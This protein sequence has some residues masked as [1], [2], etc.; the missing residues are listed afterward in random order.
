M[1]YR[2]IVGLVIGVLAAPARAETMPAPFEDMPQIICVDRDKAIELLGVYEQET[3]R[4]EELLADC[5]AQG[6]CERTTFS[7]RP[8]ADLTPGKTRH[9]GGIREGHVFAVEVTGGDVLKG[10]TTVYMLVNI[11]HDNEA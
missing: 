3:D 1:R 11:M 4:G 7:G 9:T 2:A 8:V 10:L 5:E 6:L